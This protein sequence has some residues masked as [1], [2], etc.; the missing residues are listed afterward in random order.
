MAELRLN[1][2]MIAEQTDPRRGGAETSLLEMARR[3]AALDQRVTL[4]TAG[5]RSAE[6]PLEPGIRRL[7]I[8]TPGATKFLRTRHF[9]THACDGLRDRGFDILHALAPCR[10]CD[11]YQP[12]GGTT[13]ET[14]RRSLAIPAPPVV[15][16]LK[17]LGRAGNLRQRL[18]MR[19]ERKL[20][21]SPGGPWVAAVSEYVRRQALELAPRHA[22]RVAVVFNGVDAPSL[23][24]TERAESRRR[25]R[26]ELGLS[27]GQR[28]ALFMAHNFRLKGLREL[29]HALARFRAGPR[30]PRLL[31]AGR[32]DPRPYQRLGRRLGLGERV[33]FLGAAT[34]PRL[35]VVASDCLAHP[36]WYDPCSRVALEALALGTPVVTTRW[37][38]AA[39]VMD[40]AIHGRVV[41]NPASAE[42]LAAALE[43][44]LSPELA[45]ACVAAREQSRTRFSMGR[46]A[47]ELLNLY[48]KARTKP[49]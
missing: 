48:E 5:R 45:A 10:G 24:D 20:L 4:V 31:V 42:E 43:E 18:L 44:A 8:P 41:E 6:E 15:S 36:T 9:L 26:Q 16:W 27:E 30:A 33:R 46:H 22:D 37:N 11:V 23:R 3:L 28:V 39:E 40:S 21:D 38:G 12:R 47:R 19:H 49:Y 34:Q 1:I 29:L 32:D 25:G 17:R 7:S 14:V 13:R 2:A 35:L